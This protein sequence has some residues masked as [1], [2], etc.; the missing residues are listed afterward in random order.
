MIESTDNW[1]KSFFIFLGVFLTNLTVALE[2]FGV[3]VSGKVLQGEFAVDDNRRDWIITIYLFGIVSSILLNGVIKL[4]SHSK[5]RFL[6]F[7]SLLTILSAVCLLVDDFYIFMMTRFFIGMCAGQI[8]SH[9]EEMLY[10]TVSIKY[11]KHLHGLGQNLYIFTL[12]ISAFISGLVSQYLDWRMV[13]VLDVIFCL[14]GLL[15]LWI[16]CKNE[17]PLTSSDRKDQIAKFDWKSV[18][19]I[20]GFITSFKVYISQVKQPWNTMG[21]YSNFSMAF[22]F[23]SLFF[24]YNIIKRNLSFEKRLINLRLLKNPSYAL[25]VASGFFLRCCLYGPVIFFP[26]LFLDIYLYQYSS[27]GNM[28]GFF[29]V[30]VLIFGALSFYLT[31][32]TKIAQRYLIYFGISILSITCFLAHYITILSEPKFFILLLLMFSLGVSMMVHPEELY[33][34]EADKA[35]LLEIRKMLAITIQSTSILISSILSTIS[36]IRYAY[37]FLIFSEQASGPQTRFFSFSK[38]YEAFSKRLPIPG[39]YQG[40]SDA[41]IYFAQQLKDQATLAAYADAVFL[42][43]VLLLFSLLFFIVFHKI[44]SNQKQTLALDPDVNQSV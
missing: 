44:H 40:S 15:L 2:S 14:S 8:I 10:Q 42:L 26:T 41:K 6:F 30:G 4:F 31:F 21:F 37:H 5:N 19:Y 27:T 28:I 39:V 12:G 13:F 11:E 32:Y 7:C 9:S 1:K 33:R 20:F 24:L 43:G 36:V 35:T 17:T 23:L 16:Y 29:T 25:A 18:I 3:T 34:D 38:Q 22:L